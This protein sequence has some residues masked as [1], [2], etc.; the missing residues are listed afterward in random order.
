M[1]TI[2]S[3]L[4]LTLPLRCSFNEGRMSYDFAT[5]WL[6]FMVA[7]KAS[8]HHWALPCCCPLLFTFDALGCCLEIKD[9]EWGEKAR[10]WTYIDNVYQKWSKVKVLKSMETKGLLILRC[11]AT[12]CWLNSRHCLR[13]FNEEYSFSPCA[14]CS[15]LTFS[16]AHHC[17]CFEDEEE[18]IL[19]INESS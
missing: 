13:N 8:S 18:L 3:F 16:L 15:K 14:N 4:L 12:Q 2:P 19:C 17:P 11:M 9:E 7:W 1:F 10:L 5:K 6:E